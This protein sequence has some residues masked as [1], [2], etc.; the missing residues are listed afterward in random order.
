M[1]SASVFV[2]I[3]IVVKCFFARL[4]ALYKRLCLVRKAGKGERFAT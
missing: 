3:E 1:R 2:L 4:H